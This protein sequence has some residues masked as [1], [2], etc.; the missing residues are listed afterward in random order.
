MKSLLIALSLSFITPVWAA[1]PV[2]TASGVKLAKKK[3]KKAAPPTA[4]AK[5]QEKKKVIKK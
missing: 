2:T 5:P 1:E 4:S 3:E